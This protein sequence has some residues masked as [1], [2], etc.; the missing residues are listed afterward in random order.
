VEVL[1][2]AESTSRTMKLPL[3]VVQVAGKSD[4]KRSA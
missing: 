2:G 3:S 1:H 4:T